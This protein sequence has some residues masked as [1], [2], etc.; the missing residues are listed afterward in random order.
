MIAPTELMQNYERLST[1]FDPNQPIEMFFEE[2]QD[3]R[4]FTVTG[5]QPYGNGSIVNVDFT[6]AFNTG[7]FPDACCMWQV[8]AAAENMWA[9]FKI[10]FTSTHR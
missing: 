8:R 1:P 3:A 7:V 10:D 4:A 9:Q 6:I 2:I 5:V